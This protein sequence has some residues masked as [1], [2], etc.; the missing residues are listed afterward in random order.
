MIYAHVL[1]QGSKPSPVDTRDRTSPKRSFL[2]CGSRPM[3]GLKNFW[4]ISAIVKGIEI[5]HMI[6]KSQLG[7]LKDRGSSAAQLFYPLAF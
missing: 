6:R 4:S 3:L 1:K 2:T 7:G 5:M